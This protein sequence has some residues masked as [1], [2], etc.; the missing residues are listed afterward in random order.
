MRVKASS[1]CHTDYQVYQGVYS[2]E[3]PFT[4]SHE[5][6]GVVVAL[7]P[8]VSE[9]WA[10]GDRVGVLNFRNAC[11]SCA[12]CRWR[13][14]E[15][16]SSDARFCEKKTMGGIS[17]ADGGF[18]EYMIASDSAL[19]KLPEGL[20]FEQAAPLM[21]AGVGAISIISLKKNATDSLQRLLH[22]M[23]SSSADWRRAKPWLLSASEAWV[24]SQYSLQ[25]SLAYVSPLL[26]VAMLGLGWRPSCLII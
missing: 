16:G 3:L 14:K 18:A 26:I 23:L 9:D 25:R 7:G 21:C 22:G 1:F 17:G 15:Y 6:A 10:I 24:F 19:V 2:T 4:G 13:L 5:P 8:N 12:G 20:S 11:G